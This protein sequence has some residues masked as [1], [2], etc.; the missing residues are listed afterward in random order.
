MAAPSS[1]TCGVMERSLRERV[2]PLL[3]DLYQFTMA[4][5]YWRSGRHQE[6]AVFELFFRDN[7]FG[8]SFSLFAGLEDC[9]LFLRGFRFTDEGEGVRVWLFLTWPVNL[10]FMRALITRSG[11]VAQYRAVRTS[12]LRMSVRED[13]FSARFSNKISL[14]KSHFIPSYA[15]HNLQQF[16]WTAPLTKMFGSKVKVSVASRPSQLRKDFREFLQSPHRVTD[17]LIK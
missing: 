10:T 5:A 12:V 15:R 1:N 13:S 3:T 17:G 9:L 4:Y 14:N 7:P 2:P 8:G 11:A 16:E 6:P